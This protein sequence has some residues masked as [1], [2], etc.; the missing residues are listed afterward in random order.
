M[1]ESEKRND[2]WQRQSKK[3][4]KKEIKKIDKKKKK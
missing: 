3:N 2:Y 4:A 1:T